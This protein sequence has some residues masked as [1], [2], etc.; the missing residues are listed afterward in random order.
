ML[1]NIIGDQQAL[2]DY[3]IGSRLVNFNQRDRIE[4]QAGRYN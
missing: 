4:R 2:Q 3:V 1:K